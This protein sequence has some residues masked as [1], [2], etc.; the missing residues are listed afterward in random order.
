METRKISLY[1]AHSAQCKIFGLAIEGKGLQITTDDTCLS[2]YLLL[3]SWYVPLKRVK[4]HMWYII[5]VY[6]D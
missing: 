5:L 1:L 6:L 4:T 3:I 2:S